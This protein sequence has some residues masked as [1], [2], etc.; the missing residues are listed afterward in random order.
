MKALIR[1]GG[2]TVTEKDNIA[3]I[4]WTT[5]APLTNPAWAGGPYKM[6]EN[7]VPQMVEKDTVHPEQTEVYEKIVEDDGYVIIDGKK[8]SKE[9]LRSLLE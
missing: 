3:G 8:Y 6:V 5:G 7:Y 2:E 9:D 1:N 4:N